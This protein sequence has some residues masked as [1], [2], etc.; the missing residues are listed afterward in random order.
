[1]VKGHRH[2]LWPLYLAISLKNLMVHPHHHPIQLHSNLTQRLSV[3]QEAK[4]AFRSSKG[5]PGHI[6]HLGLSLLANQ[7]WDQVGNGPLQSTEHPTRPP[8]AMLS[9]MEQPTRP[10]TACSH[11]G[12]LALQAGAVES[13][14]S[15]AGWAAWDVEK[16][17]VPALTRLW[18]RQVPCGQGDGFHYTHWHIDVGRRQDLWAVLRTA[19]H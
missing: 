15:D 13:Q 6:S 5:P 10:P 8:T 17:L 3:G 4:R 14:C 9:P 11:R 12:V 7:V 16:A 1:M 2:K 18:L 19:K